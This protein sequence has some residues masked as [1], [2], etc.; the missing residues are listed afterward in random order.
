MTPHATTG[1]ERLARA[2]NLTCPIW[3]HWRRA[4]IWCLLN[5]GLPRCASHVHRRLQHRDSPFATEIHTLAC[6]SIRHSPNPTRIP[7]V[8]RRHL[9]KPPVA[10][11]TLIE[12]LAVIGIM[13]LLAAF[14]VPA[15]SRMLANANATKGLSNLRQL[16]VAL[17]S[18]SSDNNGWFPSMNDC[19]PATL[20]YLNNDVRAWS[21]PNRTFKGNTTTK[22]WWEIPRTYSTHENVMWWI[23]GSATAEEKASKQR[24]TF[25]VQR[26]NE[27]VLLA[28]S[29]Q[30]ANGTASNGG[31]NG[32]N[33]QIHP[34]MQQMQKS[35]FGEELLSTAG[36]ADP[37]ESSGFI[38]YRQPGNKAN[39]LF[40]DGHTAQVVKGTLKLK[41]FATEY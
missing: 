5:H 40:V 12:L 16:G 14:L 30:K 19:V 29:T 32:L 15:A 17:T 21:C 31:L 41:N 37:N 24:K 2:A 25:K 18:Y 8:M 10:G 4:L 3:H 35:N 7:S 36:D 13:A 20:P 39:I 28:D 33:G 11:F 26:P 34:S 38:R 23:S 1:G 22:N 27:V 9:S 6:E